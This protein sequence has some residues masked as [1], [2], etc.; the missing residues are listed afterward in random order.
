M[1]QS[2]KFA[3]FISLIGILLITGLSACNTTQINANE[4]ANETPTQIS[5]NDAG[6]TS[7]PVPSED[8]ASNS[9]TVPAIKAEIQPTFNATLHVEQRA[10]PHLLAILGSYKPSI[11]NEAVFAFAA[12]GKSFVMQDGAQLSVWRVSP[13]KEIRTIPVK[14]EGVIQK[15]ALSEDNHYAAAIL[16]SPDDENALLLV[17]KI[18][19]GETVISQELGRLQENAAGSNQQADVWAPYE[20]AFIPGTNTLACNIGRDVQTINVEGNA[21]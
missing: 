6:E 20:L 11:A 19:S 3:L 18:M 21:K 4:I 7:T 9:I 10:E 12:D 17:W 15:I 13:L 8:N 2:G 5:S 1:N 14:T 16:L